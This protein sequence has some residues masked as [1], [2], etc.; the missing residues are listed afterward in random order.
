MSLKGNETVDLESR[1]W[2]LEEKRERREKEEI[3]KRWLT[4]VRVSDI[5]IRR[6]GLPW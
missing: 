1:W 2:R 6:N 5:L 4:Q 3:E